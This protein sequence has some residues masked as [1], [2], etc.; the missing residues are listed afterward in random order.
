MK[1][2]LIFT[3]LAVLG[4]SGLTVSNLYA[5][6]A[7]DQL[8]DAAESSGNVADSSNSDEVAREKAGAAFDGQSDSTP[9]PVDLRDKEGIVDPNDLKK[10]DPPSN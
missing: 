6:S 4:M 2:S 5:D 8:N 3:L 1:K 10:Y 7:L 9:P